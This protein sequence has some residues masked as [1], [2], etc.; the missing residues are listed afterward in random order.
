[1]AL[2]IPFF[3]KTP[4]DVSDLYPNMLTPADFTFSMWSF[5]YVLLG[6]FTFHQ[7]L[8][9]YQKAYSSTHEVSAIGPLFVI[10][11]VLNISWLIAWQSLHIAL[12]FGLI[13]VLWVVLIYLVY[14]LEHI[15]KVRLQY[16]I[17]FSV[18]LG[19][20]S[21]AA[22]ANLNVLFIHS[23]FGFFGLSDEHWTATLIG[24]GICGTLFILYLSKDIWFTA[25]LIWAFFGIYVKNKQLDLD[26]N[27]VIYM[28]IIAMVFLSL[29][30][31]YAAMKKWQESKNHTG[32]AV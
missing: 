25:V 20:I 3:G 26:G 14:R 21:V 2:Q 6:I 18:Y 29:V 22:L 11:C 1:M 5:I 7:I 10:S 13:F 27:W 23:G 9:V 32:T 4:G 12:A 16:A 19:W 15:E 24:I 28:S 30:G 31:G 17:P 8:L